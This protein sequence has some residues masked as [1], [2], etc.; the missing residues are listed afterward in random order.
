MISMVVFSKDRERALIHEQ[1]IRK[2]VGCE[3]EYIKVDNSDANNSLKDAYIEGIKKSKGDIILFIS[4]N[5]FPIT[6]GWGRIL[7]EK[8]IKDIG[9]VSI[10]GSTVLPENEK[11]TL[12]GQIIEHDLNSG[13]ITLDIYGDGEDDKI[14]KVGNVLFAAI[15]RDLFDKVSVNDIVTDTNYSF[16]INLFKKISEVTEL[17]ITHDIMVKN[18]FDG[19]RIVDNVEKN[20]Q[21]V[22]LDQLLTP[23]KVSMM[24]DVGLK[25][26]E[27]QSVEE[28]PDIVLVTGM[29]RSGTSSV[30]GLLTLCGY[31]AGDDNDLLNNNV[32][33]ADNQKGHFENRNVVLINDQILSGFGGNWYSLP[34]QEEILKSE[35]RFSNVVQNF[36]SSFKGSIIKDPRLSIT[37]PIWKKHCKRMKNVVYCFRN[38]L[39]VANSLLK[40]NKT[41][42]EQGLELWYQYNTY[43]IEGL[44]GVPVAIVDYDELSEN[45]N[46]VLELLIKV[47]KP[48]KLENDFLEKTDGFFDKSLNHNTISDKEMDEVPDHIKKLYDILLSQKITK[49]TLI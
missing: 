2:S 12:L 37:L 11:N 19:K 34:K 32:P 13:K 42:I 18:V 30:A 5:Y 26:I 44:K 21:S 40:R 3:Y 33:Q 43:L 9:A 41:P 1:F 15:K 28:L 36:N 17:I 45:K 29:H 10:T 47:L 38:P 24:L 27:K 48:K 7:D 4:E 22:P 6:D 39:A 8:F 35:V 46:L 16:E 31:S 23:D 49:L 14:G 25:D 20:I